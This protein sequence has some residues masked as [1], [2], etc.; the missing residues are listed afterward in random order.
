[1]KSVIQAAIDAIPDYKVFLTV[2]ELDES[3]RRLAEEFPDRVEL[4]VIGRSTRGH[5]IICLKIGSGPRNA[6]AFACPHPNEPIGAM[7]LEYLSRRLAEDPAFCEATGCTWY[8]VK[9]SDPDGTRLNEGWF[10]GPFTLVNYARN[11]YRP[12]MNHQ[13]EWTFPIDYQN[14]HFHS[15]ISETQALMGLM[16]EIKPEF[17]YSLHNAG[18]GGTYWYLSK[19]VPQLGEEL[20]PISGRHGVPLA[21]GEPEMPFCKLYAPAVYELPTTEQMYDYYKSSGVEDPAALLKQGG[22]SDSYAKRCG[23]CLS[24]VCELP[25]FYDPRIED[26]SP[27]ETPRR[28][29]ILRSCEYVDELVDFLK[30]HFP[31]VAGYFPDDNPFKLMVQNL[32]DFMGGDNEAKRS[33]AQSDESTLAPAKVSELFDNLYAWRFNAMC[34]LGL[35]SHM[36]RDALKENRSE[37]ERASIEEKLRLTDEE[38]DRW[39]RELEAN[40]NYKVIP[41][42][43]LIA[44]QL[45][46]AMTVLDHM[47]GE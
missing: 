26:M 2:D 28:E 10:K 19:E 45:E 39:S 8:I 47:R 34:F 43:D 25:Y 21:L 1:M 5:E 41:I 35:F 16:D 20:G 24:M 29:A 6:L 36:L 27:T 15:P 33:W 22:S 14:L 40:V 17:L 30:A 23:P 13:V 11:Y 46:S 38:L 31:A 9:C 18:F 42:R 7:T 4:R 12:A 3:S 32:M 44:I 37:P